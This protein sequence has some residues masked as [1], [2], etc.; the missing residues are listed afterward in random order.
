MLGHARV[1]GS[2]HDRGERA[3]DV[4][5]DRA[6]GRIARQWKESLSQPV[7]HGASRSRRSRLPSQVPGSVHPKF[8]P[9]LDRLAQKTGSVA[10]RP[11]ELPQGEAGRH[12]TPRPSSRKPTPT[13]S[14]SVARTMLAPETMMMPAMVSRAATTSSQ[15]RWRA[16]SAE[17]LEK[18]AAGRASAA[19]CGAAARSPLPRRSGGGRATSRQSG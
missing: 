10:P 14:A 5:Q 6:A 7:C 11:E 2:G 3:V 16:S 15:R 13:I 9:G 12:H 17:G 1:L 4:A 19:R 18:G 8:G